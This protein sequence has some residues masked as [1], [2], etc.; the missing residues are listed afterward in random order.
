MK[1]LVKKLQLKIRRKCSNIKEM[2]KKK[3]TKIYHLWSG[4]SRCK[5]AEFEFR[6]TVG[7]LTLLLTCELTLKNSVDASTS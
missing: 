5:Q 4:N 2:M 6:D 3:K 1:L 7:I